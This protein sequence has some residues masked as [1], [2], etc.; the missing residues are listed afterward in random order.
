MAYND[1]RVPYGPAQVNVLHRRRDG[2]SPRE[3]DALARD[4]DIP[5]VRITGVARG[6]EPVVK[7]TLGYAR[8]VFGRFADAKFEE[9]RPFT[10][11]DFRNGFTAP[12][13]RF[14]SIGE[15]TTHE[16]GRISLGHY[17]FSPM[18]KPTVEDIFGLN[19]TIRNVML[20]AG[21]IQMLES[22]GWSAGRTN[23]YPKALMIL[24]EILVS[25]DPA[26]NRRRRELFERLTDA[27]GAKGWAEYR[28][29]VA[30]QD[31]VMAQYSFNDHVL[32]R[33]HETVKD[34]ID[35]NG[36]LAPGKSGIWPK[37]FRKA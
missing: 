10:D 29:P 28:A 16:P 12:S 14:T 4:A 18:F 17:Y 19:D 5:S 2:G 3:W 34:A 27:C 23:S 21:D 25:P 33:F 13:I 6:P 15:A 30:F 36:I 31:R 26:V 22:Y 20:D 8:E 1:G 9:Q 32:R 37:R 7:A 35:P 11:A 24:M